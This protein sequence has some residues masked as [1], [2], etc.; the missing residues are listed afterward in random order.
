[1]SDSLWPHGLQHAR[2][3]I[4]NFL[5]LLKLMSIESVMPSSHLIL[6]CSLLLSPSIFSSIRVF[7]SESVLHIKWPKYW[8]FSFSIS[9][10]NEYC[11][12]YW[13]PINHCNCHG[14]YP[15]E[16]VMA[17]VCVCLVTCVQLSAA[18]STIACQAPLSMEFSRQEYWSGLPFHTP[19]DLP[20]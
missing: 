4:A 7:S 9:P 11:Q 12:S 2:L 1:M 3:S 19:E 15:C 16:N 13:S 14:L 17:S 18:P 10:S 6:C 5:S 8:S 20:T